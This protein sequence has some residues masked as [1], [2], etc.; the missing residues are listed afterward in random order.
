MS[1]TTEKPTRTGMRNPIHNPFPASLSSECKKAAKIIDS[2]INPGIV[3]D[4][5]IPRKILGSAKALIICTVFKMGFLGSFR[6]GSGI[7]VARMPDGSWTAPSAVALGG[8]GGGGQFG[9]ELTDFV[10]VLSTDAAV[11]TFVE[12]G[13]LTL[14]T[15]ISIA[16]G[17]GRSAE[18]DAMI[19]TKS[20]AGIY[21][22]SKTRGVYG[23]LTLE[24]GTI[25]ERS[26]A[27]KKLYERK[28]KA[29]QLLSG[30]IPPP[31][32]AEPLIRVLNSECLRPQTLA[33]APRGAEQPSSS[34]EVPPV[35][36][37]QLDIGQPMV[38]ELDA[39]PANLQVAASDSQETPQEQNTQESSRE[40]NPQDTRK[41]NTQEQPQEMNPH[42]TRKL[43]EQATPQEQN[44]QESH[45]GTNPQDSRELNIQEAPRE[46]STQEQRQEMNPQ[47][48]PR[49]LN[50]QEAPREL[51]DTEIQEPPLDSAP[52]ST[53]EGPHESPSDHETACELATSI[54][55]ETRRELTASD[56]AETSPDPGNP[57]TQG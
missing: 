40:L 49:E 34:R 23:G 8:L 9:V 3:G 25:V 27:N 50:T 52:V 16:L 55:R 4:G 28:L 11:A 29:K 21:S 38:F 54:T 44:T 10:F 2:F 33:E 15:N 1:S 19:S 17:P 37:L 56:A 51:A 43:T 18:T 57:R 13:I 31:P 47:D 20:V 24:A 22:Y 30:E 39:Q 53:Q 14:G 45:P 32:D 12:S 41:L 42:D 5:G 7:I 36:P 35:Q 48:N 26:S 46:S 6:F